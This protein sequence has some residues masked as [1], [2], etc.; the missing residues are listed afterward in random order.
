MKGHLLYLKFDLTFG[1]GGGGKRRRGGVTI[2][3]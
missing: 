1:E 2:G 3:T